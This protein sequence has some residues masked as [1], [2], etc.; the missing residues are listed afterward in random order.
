MFVGFDAPTKLKSK[1]APTRP[2]P[3]WGRIAGATADFYL[4]VSGDEVDTT[5]KESLPAMSGWPEIGIHLY[6]LAAGKMDG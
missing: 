5:Q 3:L 2:S 4:F 1:W 6:F